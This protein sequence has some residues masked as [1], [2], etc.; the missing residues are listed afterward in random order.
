MTGVDTD[1]DPVVVGVDGSESATTALRWA[2]REAG[3]RG[4]PLRVVHAWLWPLFH[5]PLGPAPGAPPGAGLQAQAEHILADALA[6]A[7]SV[8]P[9]VLAE[10]V[11]VVGEPA[12]A[13]M[14]VAGRATLLVVGHRGLGGFSGLLLGSTGI[15]ISAHASCP[16]V[17]VRGSHREVGAVVVG[18]DGSAPASGA[19]VEAAFQARLRGAPLLVVHAWTAPPGLDQLD[20]GSSGEALDEG[21]QSG[22]SLLAAAAEDVASREP[23]VEVET[24]L[25]NRAAAELVD[26]SADAQ[27]VVV[28][29]RG[30]GAFTGMLLGSVAHALIHHAQC[31]VLVHRSASS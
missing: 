3:R 2:A 12:T 27:L 17:V 8:A 29:C 23:E 10:S 7:R 16:V 9:D 31:P 13:L 5:V 6:T 30:A 4:V 24:R 22:L 14:R 11:L 26:A 20:A 15:A 28:G 21:R 1:R 19:L 18:V 25:V